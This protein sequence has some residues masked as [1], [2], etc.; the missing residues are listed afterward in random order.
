MTLNLS[1]RKFFAAGAA[2][3][4]LGAGRGWA[5]T[6][7]DLHTRVADVQLLPAKYGQTRIWGFEGRAPGPEI[8]VAQGARVQRRLINNLPDATSTHWHGIRIDN[9]M[10]GVAGLTQNAIA[11]G[12]SFQYDFVAPDAG[13]Y[14]Y[15][16]HN[17]SFEQ[18]ARGLH[19]ALI[20]EEPEPIDIDR[21]EVL[22]LDDWL[23]D[24][25]TAQIADTFGAMHDLSHAGRLG[26]YTT[27]N[28]TYNLA[29]PVKRHERLRLRMINAANA[30]VFQLA[31]D[32]LEG[33]IVA[34]DG[35]PLAQPRPIAGNIVLAPAQRVDLI[36]DVTAET[37][38]AGHIVQIDRNERFSQVAFEVTGDATR[39][40]R[41]AP[42]ALPPN[43]HAMPDLAEATK[44]ELLMQ[45]GAMGG[46]M[47]A[48]MGGQMSSMRDMMQSGNFWAFNG[49]V[50]GM[51]GAPLAALARGETVRLKIT[52]DTA[53]PHA[54]HLHG[55]HF[56]EMAPDGILGPLRD[57]TLLDRGEVRDIAIVAD[58]PGK[59][60]LHC[61]ML[62]HA[63]SGM[64]TWIDVA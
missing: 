59:W 52:N 26:N 14:W 1:R 7:I 20:V 48:M 2:L 6:P 44:L 22:I 12:S 9:A 64:M 21:E 30:R 3:A 38:G 25:D 62:S 42:R 34:L 63:A 54:M 50:G 17:R 4:T 28:A 13:T 29:L 41:D 47:G 43:V 60:L 51:D 31:L 15:H 45:G 49:A 23:V 32:G 57:T 5:A 11:P 18:V 58:N 56:H 37:G 10:D 19:G 16:A 40:R 27:T 8:R 35:M 53:F 36:V 39:A 46:M 24:P 33:W 61:H 55:M